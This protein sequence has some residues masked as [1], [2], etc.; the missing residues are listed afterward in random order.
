MTRQERE[1]AR[2]KP[3]KPDQI[4]LM[5]THRGIREEWSWRAKEERR[6]PARDTQRYEEETRLRD[7]S[8]CIVDNPNKSYRKKPSPL[9][10]FLHTSVLQPS[11]PLP[12]LLP[13]TPDP[14]NR[15]GRPGQAVSKRRETDSKNA[16]N[17]N[18]RFK[19]A[20]K[21]PK[22]LNGLIMISRA[23]WPSELRRF[24]EVI[25]LDFYICASLTGSDQESN[26]Q[27]SSASIQLTREGPSPSSSPTSMASW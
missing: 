19:R 9:L 8:Q 4:R 20:Q 15:G 6:T 23:H 10:G 14:E 24:S 25:G 11:P 21:R 16:I 13:A 2:E 12:L 3:T 17:V 22:P 26:G 5:K 7:I 1:L 18:A 27:A